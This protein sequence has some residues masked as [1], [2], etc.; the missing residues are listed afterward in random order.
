[1]LLLN[2]GNRT[3]LRSEKSEYI[4]SIQIKDVV[5]LEVLFFVPPN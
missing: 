3:L 5:G 2:N 1:M 4:A